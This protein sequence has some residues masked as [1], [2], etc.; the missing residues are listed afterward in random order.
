MFSRTPSNRMLAA[1]LVAFVASIPAAVAAAGQNS[2]PMMGLTVGFFA[3]VVVIALLGINLPLQRN[4]A[5]DLDTAGRTWGWSNSLLA[6]LVYGWGAAAMFAVY[7][8]SA[9]SW[10]H[11]WQYGAGM[12]LLAALA[13]CVARYLLG[14]NR[15]QPSRNALRTLTAMTL[16]Q[17]AFVAVALVYLTGS[18]ALDTAK[19]DRAANHIF[20]AGGIALG[21]ISVVSLLTYRRLATRTASR[22]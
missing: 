11:W 22:A 8:L 9:L 3:V 13:Y 16:L 17:A 21:L 14:N 2:A 4:A 20:L 10:R 12:A 6:T 19:D 5:A 18:G 15:T 1:V 7:G